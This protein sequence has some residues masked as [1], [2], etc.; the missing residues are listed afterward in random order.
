M[1]IAVIGHKRIP[2]REGGIEKGVEMHALRMVE[3]GHEVHVYNRGNH[4]VF[5]QTYVKLKNY[6][7]I[8]IITIPTTSGRAEVPIYSFFATLRAIFGKYDVISYRASGSC[9]M[10]PIA[11]IFGIRTIAS[12]HG[13]DSKREK[14][15][16]FASFYLRLGEKIAAKYSS[17]C[18]VLSK[19]VQQYFKEK[20]NA[21]TI[22]FANGVNEVAKKELNTVQEEFGLRKN[23]YYLSLGRIAPEKGLY[24][25]IR[26]F[27][28]VKT[29]KKLV[30]AGGDASNNNYLKELKKL[31]K[32]DERII[33][34]G[35]VDGVKVSELFSNAYTYII[36][37]DLEGMA[38]TLL[39]AMAFGNCCIVSDI[40]ENLEVV[41]DHALIF[42]KGDISDLR[43]KITYV[44]NKPEVVAELG[45]EISTYVLRK[46]S[47]EAVVDQMLDI[48][49]GNILPY[50]KYYRGEKN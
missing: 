35:F 25:L 19:S 28:N 49:E 47:W 10:I 41:D 34:T 11:K 33:F 7:G 13:I 6:K 38:N 9:I 40:P 37:S 17:E 23:D 5:D 3:R 26:A 39:E 8:K 22:I 43:E 12:I 48:Y 50:S 30:I 42:K 31:A 14:W 16:R 21:E 45:S 44:E 2:S 20:Y 18:L 32:D 29:T 1:K 24:Y 36:P 4:H 15:G 46:Y 27:K